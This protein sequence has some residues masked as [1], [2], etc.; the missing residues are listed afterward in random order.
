MPRMLLCLLKCPPSRSPIVPAVWVRTRVV[1]QGKKH[2]GSM[3][4]VVWSCTREGS[5]PLSTS[6]LFQP[7]ETGSGEWWEMG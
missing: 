5:S 3:A 7:Q 6:L 1:S 2:T 4:G